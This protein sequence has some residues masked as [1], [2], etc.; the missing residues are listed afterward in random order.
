[1]KAEQISK[2]FPFK[3]S[4]FESNTLQKLNVWVEKHDVTMMCSIGGTVI[5]SCQ[6]YKIKTF[7]LWQRNDSSCVV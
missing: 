7:E 2:E 5:V 3:I 4:D 1:M 6:D